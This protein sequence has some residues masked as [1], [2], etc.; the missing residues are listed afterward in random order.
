M[1]VTALAVCPNTRPEFKTKHNNTVMETKLKTIF[2]K[3]DFT[4][5]MRIRSKINSIIAFEKKT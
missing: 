1:T 4:N 2:D 3:S 5:P